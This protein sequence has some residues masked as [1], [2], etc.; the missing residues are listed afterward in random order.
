MKLADGK[1]V[2]IATVALVLLLSAVAAPSNATRVFSSHLSG[3]EEVPSVITLAQGQVVLMVSKDATMIHYILIAANIENAFMAHI[4]IA[5][6]GVNGAI[7]V[8]LYGSPPAGPD[9]DLI[10]GRFSGVLAKGTFTAADLVGPL[11]GQPL[12]ALIS[13]IEAGN[14]YVNVHT[15]QFPGGEIRGQI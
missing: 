15:I 2:L 7:V 12:S 8:W 13:E 11:A 4:H 14:A 10:P 1:T 6:A 9:E 5:P 3:D